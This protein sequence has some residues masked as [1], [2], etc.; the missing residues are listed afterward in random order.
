MAN[1]KLNPVVDRLRGRIGDLVFKK[2]FGTA[3]VARKPE[4]GD[5]EFTELQKANQERFR[6]ATVYGKMAMADPQ[7]RVLYEEA[8]KDKK[9][10]VFSVMIA[11]FFHAPTVDEIDLSGFTGQQ[12]STIGV[13]ASDDFGVVGV[14]VTITDQ[15]GL[16][17][18]QGPAT[19]SATE[20]GKWLYTTTTSIQPGTQVRVEAT[21]KDRPGNTATKTENT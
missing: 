13:R 19:M 2:V 9:Q 8:A 1:V 21:A 7:V 4:T 17:I 5:R 3:Y 16:A 20:P 15:A 6:Q 14:N 12:G 18:E 10:P 11:D